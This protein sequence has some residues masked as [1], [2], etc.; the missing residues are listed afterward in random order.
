MSKT[1]PIA[2]VRDM[3]MISFGSFCLEDDGE[4]EESTVDPLRENAVTISPDYLAQGAGYL[5][6]ES[7]GHTLRA[8]IEMQSWAEEPPLD[9]GTWEISADA[10]ITLST[11]D[12]VGIDI[13]GEALGE[14][15][16]AGPP[17]ATFQVRV[18]CRG[19]AHL[20]EVGDAFDLAE[21]Q[22]E[23]LVQLWPCDSYSG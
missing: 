1:G 21:V 17:G 9:A 19:R 18:H 16:H 23:Y 4:S 5:R 8:M 2:S 12:V 10:R 22:E 14:S 15:L 11:G 7:A 6:V 3:V 13:C 20:D